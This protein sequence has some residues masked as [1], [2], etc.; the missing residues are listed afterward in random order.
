VKFRVFRSFLL[1]LGLLP[2]AA[3]AQT[4]PLTQDAYVIP[5][6]VSNFGSAST[7]NVGGPTA[8][9]ALAQFNLSSLPAGTTSANIAGATFSLF[10]NKVGAGGTVNISVANGVWTELGVNGTNAPAAG[11]AVASG[12]SVLNANQYVFVDATQAVKNWVSGIT[13]NSGFIITP[14]DG[15]VNIA[16]DSKESATTSHPATLTIVLTS[17]GASGP[18]G[19]TGATGPTGLTGTNGTNGA[20]GPTGATGTN[21]TNG[22]TGPTGA[23]GT[24]GTNGATGPTGATGTNGI[25]GATGPTGANGTN[26]TNGTNGATGPTGSAGP[27][28]AQ[29]PTGATG[30]T[31]TA[32]IYGDGSDGATGPC[33]IVIST[34]WIT[35]SP[36]TGIQ[37]TNFSISTGVTLNVPSGTVIR[38][39][40]TATISGT[41]TV[42][43]ATVP[44][45]IASSG[46]AGWVATVPVFPGGGIAFPALTLRKLLRPGPFGGG[47]GGVDTGFF[48]VGGGT[49]TILSAGAMTIGPSGVINANGGNGA[50]DGTN[51]ADGG[52]GGGFVILGSKTSVTN[53]GAINA[54]GGNGAAGNPGN[55]TTSGG[56]GGGVIHLL[57]PSVIAGTQTVTGG[58]GGG[59]DNG[60]GFA[61]GGG[62]SG[63]NGGPAGTAAVAP[64]GQKFTTTVAD[65]A[66]LFV[67]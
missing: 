54:K 62:A 9:Q 4:V 36:T 33:N 45:S 30:A 38:A 53:A 17:S 18:T 61:S 41:L 2:L 67:P 43:D 19:P 22:A 14:A 57:G 46:G 39:T 58:N 13:T 37:C 59:A 40:G 16:F 48:G 66:T 49:V 25:N 7:M 6:N 34:N 3:I 8:A 24:N 47:P 11:A 50:G 21:G 60:A 15:T 12:V 64:S 42:G 35:S 27:A 28:G 56:G 20:T 44:T 31:G 52:G 23:T 1:A 26:G 51:I 63:G 55:F 5:G 65:P 32:S 29:G 10:V